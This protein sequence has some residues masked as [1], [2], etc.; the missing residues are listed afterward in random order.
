MICDAPYKPDN[1]IAWYYGAFDEW[2]PC[3][4]GKCLYLSEKKG[5]LVQVQ[6]R[7]EPH[8]RKLAIKAPYN[9]I[10]EAVG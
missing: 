2:K 1:A 8:I 7:I 4:F 5:I 6:V 10:L 9:G 3:I